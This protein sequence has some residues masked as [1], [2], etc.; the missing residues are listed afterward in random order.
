MILEDITAKN[1]MVVINGMPGISLRLEGVNE[2]LH[3]SLLHRFFGSYK[4][5]DK[6]ED[7]SKKYSCW[8]CGANY[9]EAIGYLRH[10]KECCKEDSAS[11]TQEI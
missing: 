8:T 9:T 2:K 4:E 7:V 6:T 10:I 5:E 11:D 1:G 3:Q